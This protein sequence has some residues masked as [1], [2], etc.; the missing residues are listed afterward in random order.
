LVVLLFELTIKDVDFVCDLGCQQAFEVL[1]VTLVD[2]LVLIRLNFQKNYAL[3]STNHQKV[4]EPSCHKE[5]VNMKRWW[6]MP[7][8]A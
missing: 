4:L 2:V 8:K 1:K 6:L 5:R 7:A 3:M